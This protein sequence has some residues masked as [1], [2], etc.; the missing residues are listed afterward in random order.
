MSRS[1]ERKP[2]KGAEEVR[3]VE[4][5]WQAKLPE[6]FCKL[7]AQPHPPFLAPCEFFALSA[8]AKGAGRSFGMLPQ[9]LPFGRAVGE[10]GL[11]GFYVTPDTREDFWP[12]LYWDEDEMFLRP[13]ASDFEAFLRHCALVG[14]YET[15]EQW[16]VRDPDWQETFAWRELGQRLALPE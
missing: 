8:I 6:A 5:F 4:A 16:E 13:I 12:V 9:Y 1:E 10:G 15:E 11:Y 7:Y 3:A 2:G 14:R